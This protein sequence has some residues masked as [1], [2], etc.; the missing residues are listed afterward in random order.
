VPGPLVAGTVATVRVWEVVIGVV[1]GLAIAWLALIGALL[2]ARPRDGA[3]REALRLLPDLLRLV[4]RLVTDRALPMGVRGRL[5][6]LGGYLA[7]PFDL[8]PDFV[9]VLGYA[10]DAIIVAWTLRSVARRAG[11]PTLRRHW[12]GT[13]EG[14]DALCRLLRL[15][16]D[17]SPPP[18]PK[19]SWWVD[20]ALVA[21]LVGL[22]LAL[23]NGVFLGLDLAVDEWSRSHRP[24]PLYWLA[25]AGNYLGQGTWLAV[26]ALGIA[27][28][29]GWRRH[30][31]RPLLPVFAAELLSG[32]TV[33]VL[34]ETLHRAPPNNQHGVAHPERLFSDPTSVSYPSGHLVVAIVWYGILALLLAGVVP[35]GWRRALR[36]VPPVVLFCTTIYL[37]FHWVTD[38][39]AGLLLGLL[40]YRL[41]MRVPWN[42]LPLGRRLT[43]A[44]W[45][46]PALFTDRP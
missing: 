14:F 27:I 43:A 44:G 15:P 24:P 1:V 38:S 23:A 4:G 12:P 19:P 39:I 18:T 9:P 17:G 31:V 32:A 35:A 28:V 40:L 2:I 7:V 6:L 33:L 16:V 30:S 25:R 41:L 20:G 13:D 36:V 37:S 26:I 21:G 11:T 29:L 46:G 3:L 42:S 45:A 5:V 10:D 34:K 8:V 22:T